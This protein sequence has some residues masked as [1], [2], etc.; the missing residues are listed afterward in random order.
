MTEDGRW[1]VTLVYS[2]PSIGGMIDRDYKIF[3]IKADSGEVV[4]M[5]GRKI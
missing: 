5:K 1:L 3:T 2:S 4:S